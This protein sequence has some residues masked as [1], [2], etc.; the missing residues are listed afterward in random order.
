MR[1]L[2]LFVSLLFVFPMGH[3]IAQVEP[4][5]E[6]MENLQKIQ[7]VLDIARLLE[8]QVEQLTGDKKYKCMKA[9]GHVVFCDCIA[10]S[11]PVV[12]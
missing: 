6:Q 10:H 9:F 8:V 5:L 4:T 11:S 12:V 2:I 1:L 3:V 7:E